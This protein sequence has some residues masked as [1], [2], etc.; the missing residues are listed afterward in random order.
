MNLYCPVRCG[1]AGRV[2]TIM[3]LWHRSGVHFNHFPIPK[4]AGPGEEL[5]RSG[6]VERAR[7][8]GVQAWFRGL[9]TER[10]HDLL[11]DVFPAAQI[12]DDRAHGVN[13]TPGNAPPA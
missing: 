13:G 1:P 10:G 8:K 7:V 9:R 6:G 12:G 3:L 5:A 4:R 2:D 11:G